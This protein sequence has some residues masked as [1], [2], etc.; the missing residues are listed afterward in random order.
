MTDWIDK[1]DSSQF[2]SDYEQGWEPPKQVRSGCKQEM[3]VLECERRI[4]IRIDL[5]ILKFL[6]YAGAVMIFKISILSICIDENAY[7]LVNM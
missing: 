3:Q 5:N 6:Q 7:M 2:R 1:C 4:S